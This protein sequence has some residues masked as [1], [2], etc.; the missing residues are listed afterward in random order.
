[1]EENKK[2]LDGKLIAA[3]ILIAAG[4]LLMLNTFNVIHMSLWHY[5]FDWRTIVI[6][7][8]LVLMSSQNHRVTGYILIGLG[9]VF[10]VPSFFGTDIRFHQVFWPIILI[11][12]GLVIISRRGKHGGVGNKQM[13]NEDG[14][15]STDYLNDIAIFGG[16][17]LRVESQNFKG[18][19][20][21]AIFGGRDLN[22]RTAQ[23]APEGCVID[24]FT[25][26]GGTKLVVPEDWQVKS[27]A[28]SL[29]G[30]FT[31]K[32]H[33]K[34]DEVKENKVLLLKGVVMFGGV[35][36]KSY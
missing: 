31:D 6:A 19:T 23:I 2:T 27:D 5:I 36:V 7:I 25:M 4:A 33:I 15:I 26:F 35:E 10:W 12:I 21:T 1:M 18:G 34:P 3:V 24:V 16:G 17:A 8:G 11:A 22:L 13:R 32:R 9:L 28:L 14:S 30:G 20:L 29:F